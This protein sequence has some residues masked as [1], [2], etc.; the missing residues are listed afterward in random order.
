MKLNYKLAGAVANLILI[1]G[2]FSAKQALADMNIV[3]NDEFNQSDGSS[4]DP[5]KWCYDLGGGGWGNGELEYYTGR[6]NNARIVGGQLVIEADQESTNSGGI[7]Y[8][9]TSARMKT[10]GLGSWA[11][12]RMEAR[13]K[14]PRGQGIW[15]AFWMLGT[16]FTL[17]SWPACGEIDIMENIGKTSDQ[18]T[19]HGT[20]HGPMQNKSDYNWG[21]GV[22]SSYTLPGGAKLADD[23][24]IYAVEWTT[25][26]IKW[27]LDTY[28]FF[29]ATPAS[30]IGLPSPGIWVFTNNPCFIILNVAVGGNWPGN[31]DTN[32]VFPQQMLVDYVRVYQQTAPLAFS[33]G[34]P[35]N[36]TFTLSWP[37]N[38]VCHVQAQ[39][40]SLA[41]G[42]NWFDTSVTTSP[43]VVSPDPNNN[44]VFYR[45]QSP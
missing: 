36:G 23:F 37:T 4:P 10:Q 41:G 39:T 42:A 15:C 35:S 27:F 8:N 26:Q 38:I 25:N 3:W 44:R 18:G 32:T 12:G 13:I 2:L 34:P 28:N 11:Y 1:A 22:G 20:I 5:T 7:N 9:Y 21:S 43:F 33:V 16:N 14:I 40:N 6:T 30:L 45:L 24:H 29:T 31:P 17:V 19:D